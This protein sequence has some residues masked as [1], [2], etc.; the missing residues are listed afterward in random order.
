MGKCW[1]LCLWFWL[2]KHRK[3]ESSPVWKCHLLRNWPVVGFRFPLAVWNSLFHLCWETWL[4]VRGL[5]EVRRLLVWSPMYLVLLE[6]FLKDIFLVIGRT[7]SYIWGRRTVRLV[8]APLSPS[9]PGFFLLLSRERVQVSG[10][11]HVWVMRL[12]SASEM[13][14]GEPN[15]GLLCPLCTPQGLPLV[16]AMVHDRKKRGNLNHC[17]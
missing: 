8:P 9:F 13:G 14:S 15:K 1:A 3:G 7:S 5:L 11:A 2:L 17:S 4:K 12:C 16:Y 10:W 6:G